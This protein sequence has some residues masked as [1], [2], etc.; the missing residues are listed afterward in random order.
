MNLVPLRFR[1][2]L[3]AFIPIENYR[4]DIENERP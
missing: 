3:I 1:S 4:E 2:A